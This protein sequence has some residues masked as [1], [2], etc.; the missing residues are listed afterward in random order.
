[1]RPRRARA[2]DSRPAERL[3]ESANR[4]DGVAQIQLAQFH[5]D[6]SCPPSGVIPLQGA[7][8]LEYRLGGR[9]MPAAAAG[10][11]RVQ[12]PC[13]VIAVPAVET[14]DGGVRQVEL[15]GNLDQAQSLGSK[16]EDLVPDGGRMSSRHRWSPGTAV[17]FVVGRKQFNHVNT[18]RPNFSARWGSNLTA[19]DTFARLACA[20]GAR[21][22]N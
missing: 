3:L 6:E 10:V 8:G 17:E 19:R 20:I 16:A 9:G 22:S 15:R 2:I 21:L 1:M 14:T 13:G 12:R 4:R 11:V 18:L 5:T 7:G